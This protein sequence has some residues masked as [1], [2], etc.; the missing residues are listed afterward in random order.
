MKMKRV[1]NERLHRD[2]R[3]VAVIGG[4][5]SWNVW[6]ALP[7]FPHKKKFGQEGLDFYSSY[8]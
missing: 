6:K 3:H 2:L 5:F 4:H 8:S 1:F 7:S